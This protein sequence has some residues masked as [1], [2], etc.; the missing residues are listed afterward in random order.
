MMA[1]YYEILLVCALWSTISLI[2]IAGVLVLI[3][4]VESER[5]IMLCKS[6]IKR[7]EK[8]K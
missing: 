4:K 7:W 5:N 2:V 3:F 1:H 6:I 8:M